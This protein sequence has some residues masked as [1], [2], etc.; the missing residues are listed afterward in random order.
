[1]P[2]P[3]PWDHLETRFATVRPWAKKAFPN[4]NRC[5]VCMSYTLGIPPAKDKG[6]A[7]LAD[8]GGSVIAAR[9]AG[10]GGPDLNEKVLDRFFIRAAQLLP[11]VQTRFGAAD[12]EGRSSVVWTQVEGKRGVVYLEDCYPTDREETAN[13]ILNSFISGVLDFR[14]ATPDID[15]F[16]SGD[17]WDLFDGG[18]M[19]AENRQLRHN[20]HPGKLFFWAAA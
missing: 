8:L 17:H 12:V 2:I 18:T 19:I 1:M 16:S 20:R 5:A 9:K 7:T 4:L 6:D 3:L 10:P 15:V 13:A 14:A 11:R